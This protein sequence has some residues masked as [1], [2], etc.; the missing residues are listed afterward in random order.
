MPTRSWPGPRSR[1]RSATAS[2]SAPRSADAGAGCGCCQVE[3]EWLTAAGSRRFIRR[4]SHRLLAGPQVGPFAPGGRRGRAVPR[5]G[6]RRGRASA[7]RAC[8]TR[9]PRRASGRGSARPG[10]GGAGRPGRTATRSPRG[11]AGSAPCPP[12]SGGSAGLWAWTPPGRL[13]GTYVRPSLVTG[14]RW[15]RGSPVRGAP[16]SSSSGTAW[17]SASGSGI[18]SVGLRVPPSRRDRVL[19]LIPVLSGQV[20]QRHAVPAPQFAQAGPTAARTSSLPPLGAGPAVSSVAAMP[21][22]CSKRHGSLQERQAAAHLPPQ[23]AAKREGPV[24]SSDTTRATDTTDSAAFWENHCAGVDPQWALGPTPSS[25]RSSPP[26]PPGRA[27]V[28]AA[29]RSTS[30]AG[31]AATPSLARLARLG[32]HRRRRLGDRP[33]TGRRRGSRGRAG[34][35][36]PPDPARPRPV[37]SRQGL[38]ARHRELLPHPCGDPPRAGPPAR[39]PKPSPPAASSSSSSTPRSPPGPGGTATRT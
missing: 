16:T 2:V 5:C 34:R 17:T 21:P 3:G 32:R 11:S 22:G 7:G 24:M 27:P 35:P 28:A 23:G 31:T 36:R 30:A 39:A 12:G 4:S 14:R 20:G 9:P 18:S 13:R 8:R 6:R 15:M 1:M 37:L 29:V 38:R 25:P 33:G 19:S 26:W 10:S